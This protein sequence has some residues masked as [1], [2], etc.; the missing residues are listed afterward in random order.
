MKIMAS[1]RE[2]FGEV[3]MELGRTDHDI[4]AMNADLSSSTKT[5]IFAK[6]FPERFFNMGIAEQNMMAAAAGLATTGKKVFASTFAVFATGRV[7]DQIRQSIAYPKTNVVIVAT[8]GGIT[9]GGDGASH[10]MVE[11]ISLMR[12]LPNMTVIIPADAVETDRVIRYIYEHGGPAYIRLPR[13][14]GPVLFGTDY[15][16]TPGKGVV[17]REG[18]DITIM[19]IGLMVDMAI[20]AAKELEKEGI[21]ARVVN[22]ACLKPIDRELIVKCARETGAIVTAEEHSVIGGLG[23]AVASVLVQEHP[24]I[25]EMLAIPDV[26]GESGESDEL[27][28]KYGLTKE[29]I[30]LKA[31]VALKRKGACQ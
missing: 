17:M 7:Y 27:M 25:Q 23:S 13:L 20:D 18:T 22:M 15:E 28:E 31:Q 12:S 16:F 1:A 9:V 11:D 4:V 21:S 3:L 19:A 24:A 10:Q 8:H 14:S 29:N 26:F 5:S 2:T 6:E 30:V